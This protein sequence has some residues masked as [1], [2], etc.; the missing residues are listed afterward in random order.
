MVPRDRLPYTMNT[1]E[2][3]WCIVKSINNFE[4]YIGTVH[5]LLLNQNNLNTIELYDIIHELG[6]LTASNT[7]TNSDEAIKILTWVRTY[8]TLNIKPLGLNWDFF[9]IHYAGLGMINPIPEIEYD[10]G[11][12]S[13]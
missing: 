5:L 12:E 3:Y 4:K 8:Y 11:Y 9:H 13:M 10:S 2:K 6:I 7:T 1:L